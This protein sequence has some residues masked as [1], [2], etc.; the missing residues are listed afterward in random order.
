MARDR[1]VATNP[2]NLTDILDVSPFDAR[3]SEIFTSRQ[4]W[5]LRLASLARLRL[6]NQT[7]V[8]CTNLFVILNGIEPPETRKYVF[9]RIL[10]FELE[11]M[12]TRLKYWTGDHMGY[13]DALNALLRK[14]KT[15]SRSATPGDATTVSMWKERGARICLI[16]ASQMVE[17]KVSYALCLCARVSED[18]VV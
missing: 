17:M 2:E 9:D 6:F 4:L 10:P 5:Y 18:A 12:H 1:L 3:S 14:C 7:S 8:E 15:M 13:L 16:I 11:V